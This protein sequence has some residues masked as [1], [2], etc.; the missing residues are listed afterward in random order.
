MKLFLFLN[1]LSLE[2]F[3]VQINSDQIFRNSDDIFIFII[4][5]TT[6]NYS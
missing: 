5:M 3:Q 6:K 2:N 4:F 1:K